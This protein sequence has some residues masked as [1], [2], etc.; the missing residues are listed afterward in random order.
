MVFNLKTFIFKESII[1]SLIPLGKISV[2][3]PKYFYKAERCLSYTSQITVASSPQA[4][5]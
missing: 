4:K 3:K 5:K 2:E 1:N